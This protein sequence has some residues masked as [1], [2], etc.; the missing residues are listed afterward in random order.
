MQ[1]HLLRPHPFLSASE[2]LPLLSSLPPTTPLLLNGVPVYPSPSLP[3]ALAISA[4]LPP[5]DAPFATY[6]DRRKAWSPYFPVPK[7]QTLP[8]ESLLNSSKPFYCT[9]KAHAALTLP[10]ALSELRL[11]STPPA[12]NLFISAPNTTATLHYDLAP[13]LLLQLQVREARSSVSVRTQD[14]H[15]EL[16]STAVSH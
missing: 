2:V 4:L 11:G 5:S 6:Y 10:T 15:R 14:G 1:A 7:P 16:P 9:L 8:L 13:N 3:A 12:R